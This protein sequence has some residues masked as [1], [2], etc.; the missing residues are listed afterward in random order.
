MPR[1]LSFDVG[2]LSGTMLRTYRLT[3]R[4]IPADTNIWTNTLPNYRLSN[5][6]S[7]VA[8]INN[9]LDYVRRGYAVR[10]DVGVLHACSRQYLDVFWPP[11]QNSVRRTYK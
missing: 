8:V 7:V 1:I 9:Q 3:R 11:A 4:H 6:T 2:S 10:G 5:N